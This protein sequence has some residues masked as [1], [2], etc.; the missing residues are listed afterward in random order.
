MFSDRP[1]E[2]FKSCLSLGTANSRWF[3]DFYF[4]EFWIAKP[5]VRAWSCST[6]WRQHRTSDVPVYNE[7]ADSTLNVISS[8]FSPSAIFLKVQKKKKN[9]H[10]NY[11]PFYHLAN[12]SFSC[13]DC[14]GS[15]ASDYL[16][17]YHA[18]AFILATPAFLALGAG[19]TVRCGNCCQEAHTVGVSSAC[20]VF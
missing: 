6:Q 3:S 11:S 5:H 13:L 16:S 18:K 10:I 12:F 7:R 17:P 9:V 19:N 8:P 4:C 15:T 2:D 14:F 20:L 1:L